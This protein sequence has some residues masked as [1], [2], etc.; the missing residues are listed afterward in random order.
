MNKLF[1]DTNA[2]AEGIVGTQTLPPTNHN[3]TATATTSATTTATPDQEPAIDKIVGHGF[4]DED[5]EGAFDLPPPLKNRRNPHHQDDQAQSDHSSNEDEAP[6]T[7]T[8]TP[9]TAKRGAI[10]KKAPPRARPN[11]KVKLA[12]SL[13][14]SAALLR[15]QANQTLDRERLRAQTIAAHDTAK[16]SSLITAARLEREAM[17]LRHNTCP[18]QAEAMK[19]LT[20]S[21]ENHID[22]MGA[23]LAIQLFE[24]EDKCRT[25]I[26]APHPLRWSWLA[27]ALGYVN[28]QEPEPLE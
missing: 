16:E 3:Q 28:V 13:D 7:T 23:S 15:T 9:V 8:S 17:A 6:I 12:N 25:F 14:N 26:N 20:E 18:S 24:N 1:G 2:T 22:T 10:G 11:T 19:I 4:D 27:L 21:W 5:D